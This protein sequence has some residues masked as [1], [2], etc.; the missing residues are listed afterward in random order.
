MGFLK[1]KI[2]VSQILKLYDEIYEISNHSIFK[3]I[4]TNTTISFSFF[5]SNPWFYLRIEHED[6]LIVINCSTESDN[7]LEKKYIYLPF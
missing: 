3:N 7:L 5:Y 2:G 1:L 6:N 4:Q